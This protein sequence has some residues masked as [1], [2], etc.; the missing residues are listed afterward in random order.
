MHRQVGKGTAVAAAAM[1]LMLTGCSLNHGAAE[2]LYVK[3]IDGL[4]EDFIMG[5]DISTVLSLEAAG[6]KYYD[7]DGKEADLFSVLHESGINY[8]RVRVWN[9]PYDAEGNGY[10]GGNCDAETA[11]EIGRRAAEAGMKLLVDFH[12]SDFWA[13]PGKQMVPKAWAQMELEEKTQAL[14]D[15]TCD[16]LTT[17]Q[18]AGAD[19]GMVQIG[20]ETNGAMCGEKIWMHIYYLM[21]AG[22]RAVRA[23]VPEAKVAVHFANPESSDNMKNYAY[24]L[25]YYDLDYDVFASSYYPFWHGTT[26]N[27]TEVLS[28]IGET[29]DKQ[30]MVAETSY[31]YTL[32]DGDDNANSIGETVNYE[33]PYPITVQGQSRAI[34]DV[35]SA[36]VNVGERG[37]GMFY[38]EPAWLPVPGETREERAALWEQYGA[39]WA[40]SYSAGYDPE[41]AGQYYGGSAWDNQAL[42]DFS[43][44]PLASLKTFALVRSGN[45]TEPVPDAVKDAE[46]TVRLGEAVTLPETVSA[47]YTDGSQQ[48]IAV[49]WEA[50]DLDAMTNGDPAVYTVNGTADGREA[51]CR[52]SMV[53]ANYVDNYS[54]EDDD[55]SMWEIE[56]VGDKT[57]QIDFQQKA[58]DAVTGEYSLHFWGENGTDFIAQ[59][60]LTGIPAGSYRFS[61]SIQGGFSSDDDTQDIQLICTVNGK[62]YT[63][64]ASVSEWNVWT[65]PAVTGIE[66]PEGAEVTVGIHVKAGRQSWGTVDDFLLN[67]EK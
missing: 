8:I 6:V 2:T 26:E 14:Y 46:I 48:E 24:K 42:F 11:G 19:I 34:A 45:E 28:F 31:A 64:P 15:Y 62:E 36:V 3:K 16:A 4:S 33:K 32:D 66:I 43:G 37:I 9:D 67:P 59:Q 47:I 5:C 51:V 44:H 39:G 22:S 1:M 60:K 20:N 7:F 35:I 53:A 29:Y 49:T 12:Y 56:N 23:T 27:L 13:D 63:A 21:D 54:F 30:V 50:A 55:R 18:N 25:A 38:W 17:I 10:G 52:V 41:D 65:E 40:S 61:L 58:L 57:T